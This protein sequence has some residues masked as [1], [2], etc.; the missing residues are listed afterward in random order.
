VPF[1][2]LKG[3]YIPA[4]GYAL[5]KE[6]TRFS[7]ER[8]ERALHNFMKSCNMCRPFRAKIPLYHYPGRCPGLVCKALSGLR[9]KCNFFVLPPRK[10]IYLNSKKW[11]LNFFC[12]ENNSCKTLKILL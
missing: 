7:P 4:Q 1:L 9:K 8:P 12:V 2:A 6:L 10:R 11:Q 3:I 5:G